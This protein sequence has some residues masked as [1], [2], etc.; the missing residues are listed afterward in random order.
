MAETTVV[1]LGP[2]NVDMPAAT[3]EEAFGQ[4]SELF[5][6][7]WRAKRKKKK[8][9]RKLRKKTR[10]TERR[11]AR[12]DNKT[13]RVQMRDARKRVKTDTRQQ[14][15]EDRKRGRQEMRLQRRADR[16]AKRNEMRAEQQQARQDRRDERIRRNKERSMYRAEQK[17][18]RQE[19][20]QGPDEEPYTD[21]EDVGYDEQG[22][23]QYLEE[24]G[25]GEEAG[26]GD[27]G[28]GLGEYDTAGGG[29]YD[30]GMGQDYD[31]GSYGGGGYA[32]DPYSGD[33]WGGGGQEWDFESGQYVNETNDAG[34]D[35]GGYDDYGTADMYDSGYDD[36][37]DVGWGAD[38]EKTMAEQESIPIH[39][40]IQ[41]A[42]DKLEWNIELLNRLENSLVPGVNTELDNK[43]NSV[44]ERIADLQ[45]QLQDFA[46]FD[47][48]EEMEADL[49]EFDNDRPPAEIVTLSADGKRR[50]NFGALPKWRQ[51]RLAVCKAR[52]KAK[53]K[54]KQIGKGK[55]IGRPGPQGQ[56]RN[57]T[58]ANIRRRPTQVSKALDPKFSPQRIVVPGKEVSAFNDLATGGPE[59]PNRVAWDLQAQGRKTVQ[60]GP[61]GTSNFAGVG[62]INW[63]SIAIGTAVGVAAIAILSQTNLFKK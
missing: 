33:E 51:R 53:M 62:S 11:Q 24:G 23:G 63:G 29:S 3:F 58:S 27:V 44:Q 57:I 12:L 17:A 48:N 26:Y 54:R 32:D 40:K 36:Y 14:R 6:K 19:L 21:Y 8:A 15:R 47:N 42:A 34:Y 45:S 50:V 43:I 31:D 39:N 10:K 55:P 4:Y 16:K 49:A 22:G 46:G 56:G 35:D 41:E 9:A 59:A 60:L 37:G 20:R 7:K 2:H 25:Y 52:C 28:E 18:Q 38:G 61:E 5:G 30:D 1:T 13:E